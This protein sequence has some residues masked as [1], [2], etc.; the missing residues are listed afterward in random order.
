MAAKSYDQDKLPHHWTSKRCRD[1]DNITSDFQKSS[2]LLRSK[3]RNSGPSGN[4][5]SFH[6]RF[7]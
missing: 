5:F 1:L 6:F 4:E 2:I 7:S 3:A